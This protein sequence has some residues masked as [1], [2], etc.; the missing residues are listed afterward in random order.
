MGT[1]TQNRYDLHPLPDL[2]TVGCHGQ[3]TH[4]TE[5]FG[6]Q[7]LGKNGLLYLNKNANPVIENVL[8]DNGVQLYV[9]SNLVNLPEGGKIIL[10][11]CKFVGDRT[12]S[13]APIRIMTSQDW[14]I[15]NCT[16][17]GT[18]SA[19]CNITGQ[20]QYDF[21]NCYSTRGAGDGFKA[22]DNIY[23]HNCYCASSGLGL[24]AHADGFQLSNTKGT[25]VET[26]RCDNVEI[27]HAKVRSNAST[28]ICLEIKS[29]LTQTEYLD[30][31]DFYE[32]GGGYTTQIGG[33]ME[34]EVI[35]GLDFQ[36]SIVGCSSQ[37]GAERIP[38]YVPSSCVVDRKQADTCLVSS[39]WKDNGFIHLLATNYVNSDRTLLVRTN[40][41]LSTF[42][43]PKCPT[44]NEIKTETVTPVG[45]EEHYKYLWYSDLPYNVEYIIPDAGAEYV[46][47]FDGQED[48]AHQIRYVEFEVPPVPT[49]QIVDSVETDGVTY[50]LKDRNSFTS[51]DV[52]TTIDS[53][54]TDE[55][56]PSALAVLNIG[57]TSGYELKSN[58]LTVLTS[59]ATDDNYM[60]AKWLYDLLGWL[61]ESPDR[62][63]IPK[64]GTWQLKNSSTVKYVSIGSDDDF[65]TNPSFYRLMRTLNIPYVM[66]TEADNLSKSLTRDTDDVFTESDAPAIF[67]GTESHT[68]ADLAKYI[69]EHPSTGEV[70][71]HGSSEYN[72]V[73]TNA[74]SMNWDNAYSTYTSG[75]GTKTFEEFKTALLLNVKDKDI[76]QGASYVEN[77]R[78]QIEE[79][80]GGY[81]DTV[82]IWG[83]TPQGEVDGITIGLPGGG[84]AYDFRENDWAAAGTVVS[85][86]YK[87]RNPWRLDR[88]SDG[89][90]HTKRL[91]QVLRSYYCEFFDHQP[92]S[93]DFTELKNALNHWKALQS[94]G[95]VSLITRKQY[96]KLGEFVTNPVTKIDVTFL[97][98]FLDINDVDV[99]SNYKVEATFEDTTKQIVTGFAVDRK[100]LDT[101]T[102]GVYRCYVNYK[103]INSSVDVPVRVNSSPNPMLTPTI[104]EGAKVSSSS[105]S[106][107]RLVNGKVYMFEIPDGVERVFMH[108]IN[109]YASQNNHYW[110][111]NSTGSTELGTAL[112]DGGHYNYRYENQIIDVSS[113]DH[114]YLYWYQNDLNSIDKKVEVTL[115][116]IVTDD[117]FVE[118]YDNTT[119]E[120][121]TDSTLTIGNT[122]LLGLLIGDLNAKEIVGLEIFTDNNKVTYIQAYDEGNQVGYILTPVTAG[123]WT[124]TINCG[125]QRL[126]KKFTIV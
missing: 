75:G 49:R 63:V 70:S 81:I 104:I 78:H 20:G 85:S 80:I 82:G 124:I 14:E 7:P 122:Y 51:D 74:D 53:S 39:I 92:F 26:W 98:G 110:G 9:N 22:E 88:L 54:S 46:V 36:R 68:L 69:F 113:A 118:C 95:I 107:D 116:P 106:I 67:D 87:D 10:R 125:N 111:F 56:I 57:T 83:G 32:N 126:E 55:Q 123:T 61:Q 101:S 2:R 99:D 47:C 30:L 102:P 33:K 41:G 97:P 89:F 27:P 108:S 64:T 96:Y 38:D 21:Y 93:H 84:Q 4:Y 59:S 28:F 44:F 103:G 66:N 117:M 31:S 73:N 112:V 90:M 29:G 65:W 18:P 121:I 114:K 62:P 15:S 8:F 58:K 91:T 48:D 19:V 52:A 109:I 71:L 24:T 12:G 72:L 77:S 17:V 5:Y 35:Q 76:A 25:K 13:T 42:I 79:A 43:I 100:Y 40:K 23:L 11:N 119:G 120:V 45:K 60:S 1:Y 37:Y 50:P 6:V 16:F 34:G 105:T 86:F 3:L 94:A 115:T